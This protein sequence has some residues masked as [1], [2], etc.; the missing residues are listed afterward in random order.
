MS[1]LSSTGVSIFISAR[2]N[3]ISVIIL[4]NYVLVLGTGR[5]ELVTGMYLSP[6][7]WKGGIS[8]RPLTGTETTSTESS[9]ELIFIFVKRPQATFLAHSDVLVGRIDASSQIA[10][11]LKSI[12]STDNQPW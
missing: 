7:S 10:Q 6:S 12:A 8:I 11:P 3:A 9:L 2:I 5:M 1:D 4:A